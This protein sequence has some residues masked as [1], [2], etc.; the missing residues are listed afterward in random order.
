MIVRFVNM[1]QLALMIFLVVCSTFVQFS[2]GGISFSI[3]LI[4]K[5]YILLKISAGS[6]RLSAFFW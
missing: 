1:L 3:L 4:H 5:L 2:S 6:S